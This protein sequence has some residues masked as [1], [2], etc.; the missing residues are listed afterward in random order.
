MDNKNK[1]KNNTPEEI[2][3]YTKFFEASKKNDTVKAVQIAEEYMSSVQY[4]GRKIEKYLINAY[5][6]NKDT[7]DLTKAKRLLL[8]LAFKSEEDHL[9]MLGLLAHFYPDED[10]NDKVVLEKL[11]EIA[12]W[13][14]P[15]IYI[16]LFIGTYYLYGCGCERDVYKGLNYY[17]SGLLNMTKYLIANLKSL[18]RNDEKLLLEVDK[19]REL[20]KY[21][22]ENLKFLIL[23]VKNKNIP[24]ELYQ[25]SILYDYAKKFTT[26]WVENSV[27]YERGKINTDYGLLYFSDITYC[28]ALG[29]QRKIKF[30]Y[31]INTIVYEVL[32]NFLNDKI[33]DILDQNSLDTVYLVRVLQA[34]DKI[35]E[36]T[37]NILDKYKKNK[38]A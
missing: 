14:R 29:S 38:I 27:Q 26:Y 6:F 11:H 20:R 33:F 37:D 24:L 30:N 23:K 15:N 4:S 19:L 32:I 34:F 1:I 16:P 36:I 13:P 17:R 7:K 10:V 31:A 5:V 9:A 25:S 8:H 22:N 35:T 3:L 12:T 18:V 2:A 21:L 28:I